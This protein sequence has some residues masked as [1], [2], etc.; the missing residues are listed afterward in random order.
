M[1]YPGKKESSTYGRLTISLASFADFDRRS[2]K[3]V[4]LPRP[5]SAERVRGLEAEEVPT[6]LLPFTSTK[7]ASLRRL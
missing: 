6:L 7:K 4:E 2:S 1:I 3:L 5:F